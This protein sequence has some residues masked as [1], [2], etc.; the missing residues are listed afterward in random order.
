MEKV[1]H[2]QTIFDN[3]FTR[4]KEFFN[5]F[6]TYFYFKRPTLIAVYAF[7]SLLCVS[8]VVS[9]IL[10]DMPYPFRSQP[11][12]ILMTLILWA[13]I[14]L[15]FMLDKKRRYKQDL[16]MNHGEPIIVKVSVTENEI[17][18][19]VYT[20]FMEEK[21]TIDFSQI[22]RTVRTKNFFILITNAKL[23]VT[24]AKDGFIK[25]TA[26]EFDEFLRE[27]FKQRRRPD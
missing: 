17:M 4:S 21:N 24:L 15:R 7:M 8:C 12:F 20:I 14:I 1:T 27:K 23:A 5:E 22:K 10:P 25:G 18:L 13:Y 6:Y 11:V 26:E 9:L 3:Q 2:M 16:E 19:G